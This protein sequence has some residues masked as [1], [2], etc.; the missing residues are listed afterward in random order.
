MEIINDLRHKDCLDCQAG[1]SS[2]D[3]QMIFNLLTVVLGRILNC[4]PSKVCICKRMKGALSCVFTSSK[5]D[6]YTSLLSLFQIT[7]LCLLNISKSSCESA[8]YVTSHGSTCVKLGWS[9]MRN[10]ILYEMNFAYYGHTLFSQK[11]EIFF[12]H[13]PVTCV[14]VSSDHN[15]EMCPCQ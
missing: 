8:S 3:K 14:P 6:H 2:R 13:C 11:P 15:S 12:R 10:E 9:Q 1:Q 7:D 5:S 4:S